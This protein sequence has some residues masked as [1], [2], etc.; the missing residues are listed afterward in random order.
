MRPSLGH[1]RIKGI[2]GGILALLVLYTVY[3]YIA[4][5]LVASSGSSA[6]VQPYLTVG[7][8]LVYFL[9]G[10]A[11]GL[12]VRVGAFANA[13]VVGAFAPIANT[14]YAFFTSPSSSS[15][16]EVLLA[17]GA[18]WFVIGV[19]FCSIGGLIWDAQQRLTA[20]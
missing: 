18:F 6:L 15:V 12:F 5:V 19:I 11:T 16:G 8:Y 2:V 3:A 20:R 9:A 4:G 13:V 1:L 10:Y 17:H 7:G 14:A